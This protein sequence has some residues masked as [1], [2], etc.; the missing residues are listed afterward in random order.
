MNCINVKFTPRELDLLTI[1]ASDQLFHREFT[2]SRLSGSIS[3]AEELD[4]GKKL[5]ERLRL[6]SER[7]K[8]KPISRRGRLTA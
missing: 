3:N 6:T 7:A 2:D 1:L 8:G 4:R 5:I